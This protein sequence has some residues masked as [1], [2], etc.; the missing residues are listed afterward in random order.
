M[1]VVE[2]A[3]A[4]GLPGE[5]G[6]A[7]PADP[8][9]TRAWF[10]ANRWPADGVRFL[11]VPGA[12]AACAV[13]LQDD[14]GGWS[15]MNCTDIAAGAGRAVDQPEPAVARA[16]QEGLRQLNVCALGYGPAVLPAAGGRF[17]PDALVTA[18]EEYARDRGRLLTFLH[19]DEED[20]VLPCLRARGWSLGVTDRYYRIVDVGQDDDAYLA[21]LSAHRRRRLRH[22]RRLLERAGATAEIHQGDVTEAVQKEVARLEACADEKHGIP[23]DPVRLLHLNERL[24]NA[25][26]PRYCV[27]LVRDRHGTAVAS[28]TVVLG[29]HA[30]L[31]RMA[32]LG[33]GSD[34]LGG[35]FHVA[36]HLPMRLA[37]RNGARSVLLGT[38]TATPKLLRGATA[39]PLLSAVPPDA[40][41][42]R[43]LLRHTDATLAP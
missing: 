12:G 9:A 4:G 18:L 42:H 11:E 10:D 28:S 38:G 35:Y 40:T 25:F 13:R 20:P 8:R 26:G 15:R 7:D 33:P 1:T 27:T 31:P 5:Y 43:T 16:R 24:R 17:D 14:H 39:R 32:G 37:R 19:L 6:A 22:D 29:R 41:A 2:H 23:G 30:V 34:A 3:T 36:Y 21:G